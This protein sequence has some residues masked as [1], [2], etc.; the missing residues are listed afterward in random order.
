VDRDAMRGFKHTLNPRRMRYYLWERP[1]SAPSLST[2][3][4]NQGWRSL[5]TVPKDKYV[6]LYF[7]DSL[8]GVYESPGALIWRR[9]LVSG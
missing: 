9:L 4:A 6:A 2:T 1:E 7:R 5:A 3:L 8:T